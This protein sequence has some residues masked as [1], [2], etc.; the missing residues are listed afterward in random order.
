MTF[1]AAVATFSL[2]EELSSIRVTVDPDNLNGERDE[3]KQ[4]GFDLRRSLR[5]PDGEPS[6]RSDEESC[7]R[8][9]V[10]FGSGKPRAE[11]KVEPGLIEFAARR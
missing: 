7:A 8:Q 9:G 1:R 5:V 2:G 11:P 3:S 6:A 4:H 10:P